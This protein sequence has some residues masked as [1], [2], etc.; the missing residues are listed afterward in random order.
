MHITFVKKRHADGS[1]CGK[2]AEIER[3]LI[4]DG[5]MASIDVVAVADMADVESLGMRLAHEVGTDFAPFFIVRETTQTRVYTIYLKFV[6]E[7]LTPPAAPV[8]HNSSSVA[9]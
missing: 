9:G 8:G 5:H 1:S 3:R 2:C 7:I 4:R 6:R